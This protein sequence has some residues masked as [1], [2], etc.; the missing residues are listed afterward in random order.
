VAARIG[1]VAVK[2]SGLIIL[3]VWRGIQG[4]LIVAGPLEPVNKE[5][6]RV[7]PGHYTIEKMAIIPHS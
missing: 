6:K 5:T 7:D 1:I 3:T 4:N 2:R